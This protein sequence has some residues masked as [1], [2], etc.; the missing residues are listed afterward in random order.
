MRRRSKGTSTSSRGFAASAD[1][2]PTGPTSERANDAEEKTMTLTARALS[3]GTFIDATATSTRVET[4]RGATRSEVRRAVLAKTRAGTAFDGKDAVVTV[5][6]KAMR[7]GDETRAVELEE[8]S[9]SG[10]G[11]GIVA[12]VT[13]RPRIK[14]SNSGDVVRE[15]E[16][17]DDEDLIVPLRG[18]RA[19]AERAL[20]ERLGLSRWLA[21]LLARVPLVRLA[22]WLV[23]LRIAHERELGPVF[24][25]ATG[26]SLIISNLGRRRAG[27]ASAYSIFN[28]GFARLPGQLTTDDVDDALMHRR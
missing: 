23:A 13:V 24:V 26:F 10:N 15:E 6:G 12:L 1:A 28:D 9:S 14:G 5:R 16:E 27:Q 3:P 22:S 4:R 2:K 25:L 18:A 7:E 19:Y 8:S 21:N 17:D 11:R 20:R